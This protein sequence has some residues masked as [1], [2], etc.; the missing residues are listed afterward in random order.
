MPIVPLLNWAVVAVST[1]N[2][3]ALL[4]LGLT[5]LL[6]AERRR[7]STWVV[8]GG[9]LAGGVF[10]IAHTAAI[11]RLPQELDYELPIWWRLIWLPFVIGPYLWYL[12]MAWHSG[13]IAGRHRLWVAIVSVLGLFALGLLLFANPLPS[14]QQFRDTPGVVLA[15]F[16]GIPLALLIYPVYSLICALLAIDALRNP[17]P[18]ERFMGDQARQRA[19]PWLLAASLML[20]LV[21]LTVGAVATWVLIGVSTGQVDLRSMR[22]I[23]LVHAFDLI[24][25]SEIAV[26]IVLMGKAIVSYEIFTGKSLP[27]GGLFRHWRNSLLL[28]AGYGTLIGL[29]LELPIEPIYRL[30][31]ATVLMTFFFA[32]LSWRSYA[33]R[34]RSMARLRPFITS[35]HLYER[36]TTPVAPP[37][38]DESA[39]FCSLCDDLLDARSAVLIP[40]GSLA[41]LVAPLRYGIPDSEPL[42][43]LEPPMIQQLS[44]SER[45]CMPIDPAQAN[46]AVWVIALWSERGLIGA[47]LIG[48]KRGGALYTQEEIEIARA[49]AERLVDTRASAELGRRLVGLQRQRLAESQVLDR[50]TRRVLHDD[51]LPQLHTAMLQLSSH[52]HSQEALAIL[53]NAHR[54]IA[55]LLH[56]LPT[57]VATELSRNGLAEALKSVVQRELAGS[58]DQVCWQIDEQAAQQVRS[59][60]NL[61]IEVLFYAAREAIRNAARHARGGDPQRRVTLS[62]ALHQS[63][64][65]FDLVVDDDGVGFTHMAQPGGSG[66]GL[67][68]HSTMVAL[69]G[70]SLIAE[71]NQPQGTSIRLR[72]PMIAEG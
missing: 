26:S 66:R 56:E 27:R 38:L 10:F 4:W 42:A 3:I 50:R 57:P 9:I 40:L 68:L 61:T 6:N 16:G 1:F 8:G 67:G 39:A 46:G 30:M 13:S 7:W 29:S 47:L 71:A 69:V 20:L 53:A 17:A 32:L 52:P 2:T 28:A 43:P 70:G 36:L 58:F 63:Q 72:I 44:Q 21:A 62:V 51:V 45:L 22:F 59:L 33:E 60:S 37:D 41:A 5:V 23:L 31:L 49:A 35:Q 14:F 11:A 34:E 55:D 19:R 54:Q 18:S 65:G 48:P 64:A 25:A 24:I 12:V 15:S